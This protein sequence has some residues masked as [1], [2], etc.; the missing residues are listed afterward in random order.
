MSN[1][2]LQSSDKLDGINT[3]QHKLSKYLDR[4]DAKKSAKNK[5]STKDEDVDDEENNVQLQKIRHQ[6]ALSLNRMRDLEEQVKIIPKLRQE[7]LAEQAEKRNLCAKLKEIEERKTIK[8]EPLSPPPLSIIQASSTGPNAKST[9]LKCEDRLSTKLF[10]TQR[11]CAT[12]LESLNMLFQ[13]NSSPTFSMISQGSV[14]NSI[15]SGTPPSIKSANAHKDIGCMTYAPITRDVGTLTINQLPPKTRAASTYT[16]ILCKNVSERL[17]T[18]Q[19]LQLKIV[20]AIKA[21]EADDK[22]QEIKERL[23]TESDLKNEIQGAIEKLQS[24]LAKA[25][26]LNSSSIG[27]QCV[28]P[29]KQTRHIGTVTDRPKTP[30]PPP[31]CIQHSIGIMA[32]VDTRNAYSTAKPETKSIGLENFSAIAKTRCTGTDPIKHLVD[33]VDQRSASLERNDQTI[34]L[35]SLDMLPSTTPPLSHLENKDL[36]QTIKIEQSSIAIQCSLQPSVAEPLAQVTPPIPINRI[37]IAIQ[38]TPRQS[39]KYSQCMPKS[40]TPPPPPLPSLSPSLPDTPIKYYRTEA[41]DT[42]DL[43]RLHD[44]SNNT[45]APPKTRDRLVNTERIR[46]VNGWTNTTALP[47]TIESGT[48]P[49]DI[50]LPV[51][52]D[53]AIVSKTDTGCGT[54]TTD[55]I[56]KNCTT[57]LAKIEIKQQTFIKHTAKIDDASPQQ[58]QQLDVSRIPRPTALI[59]PRPERKFTR[60]NTYTISPTSPTLPTVESGDNFTWQSENATQTTINTANDA[61]IS[62]LIAETVSHAPCPAETL[63]RLVCLFSF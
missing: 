28:A 43:I 51:A 58:Q 9:P 46:T 62:D 24:E 21:R 19:D 2:G 54:D 8:I 5:V 18:E 27:V 39:S 29:A 44:S 53:N 60:Q 4:K 57:C 36:K 11:V 63:L 50:Q 41:T 26:L 32:V 20:E 37:S 14:N 56:N 40:K 30:P 33:V 10:S 17:F 49:M 12:S 61:I 23:F 34:S 13:N 48:N 16:T 6:M 22:R 42:K 38:H 1:T 55:I 25:K 3:R 59:S 31:P 7:L 15:C 35:K 45:D 47:K 52:Q